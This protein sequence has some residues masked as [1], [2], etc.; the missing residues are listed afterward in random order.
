MTAWTDMPTMERLRDFAL[1]NLYDDVDD[2]EMMPYAVEPLFDA[3]KEECQIL[4]EEEKKHALWQL[5]RKS[6]KDLGCALTA[7]EDVEQ[8]YENENRL[9][10]RLMEVSIG[11][12]VIEAMEQ[13]MADFF[14]NEKH[15]WHMAYAKHF[16][17]VVVRDGD[18]VLDS[19]EDNDEPPSESDDSD[20]EEEEEGGGEDGDYE[21]SE[22]SEG[23]YDSEASEADT[24]KRER[25][26]GSGSGSGSE[27]DE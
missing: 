25:D 22:G 18:E 2:P 9:T 1:D 23:C 15:K 20:D 7:L 6:R 10:E 3:L 26:S 13:S 5:V 27:E 16:A 17:E 11:K 12:G 14:A 19:E 24:R 8:Q 21:G 4:V